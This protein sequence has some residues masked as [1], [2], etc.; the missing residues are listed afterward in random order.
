MPPPSTPPAKGLSTAAAAA[1]SLFLPLLPLIGAACS[2]RPDAGE[3]S[4]GDTLF[5]GTQARDAVQRITAKLDGPARA[6]QVEIDRE[7]LKAQIQDAETPT[8]VDEHSFRQVR[9][10][11]RW[12]RRGS[13]VWG[14]PE[15]LRWSLLLWSSVARSRPVQVS[16]IVPRLEENFFNLADVDF[17]AVPATVREA[18]SRVAL[19]DGGGWVERVRIQRRVS[20]L[21]AP[22]SGEIEWDI[23]VRSPRESATA[24]ADA[25]GRITRVNLDGTMRAKTVDLREGGPAFDEA[26][27]RIRARFGGDARALRNFQIFRTYLSFEGRDS[28]QPGSVGAPF[29]CNLSGLSQSPPPLI[30]EMPGRDPRGAAL[31]REAEY[32]AVNEVDWSRLPELKKAALERLAIPGGNVDTIRL[33]RPAVT[34][35]A[36]K[37]VQWEISARADGGGTF[38]GGEQGSVFFDARD[39]QV[40]RTVLPPS[41]RPA[42]NLI[43]PAAIGRVLGALRE[44]YGPRARF[45]SLEF[46]ATRCAIRAPG[47]QDPTKIQDLSYDVDH[48]SGMP[49]GDATPYYKGW[50]DDWLFDLDELEK[51]VLPILGDLQKKAVERLGFP[52]G[53]KIER[54]TF[55]RHTP[56]YPD[57]KKLLVEIRPGAGYMIFDSR[58]GVVQVTTP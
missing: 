25:R 8:H 35:L 30:P 48:F 20:L 15:N 28:A 37:P 40:V 57:N 55:Y 5:D 46:S 18:R 7:T 9:M 45:M 38:Y 10:D 54:V 58:G 47:L 41:R 33:A 3:K 6:F 43:E 11:W 23:A 17:A 14:D 19:T 2:G 1:L 52:A 36:P 27:A 29:I 21:P 39:G 49:G 44:N 16:L 34:G 13:R 24:Y 53:E 32:F 42:V 50:T 12:R 31:R 56:F 4:G 22:R 26:V 51:T